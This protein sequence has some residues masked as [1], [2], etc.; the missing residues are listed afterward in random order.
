MKYVYVGEWVNL[1]GMKW[2]QK[3]VKS[4]DNLR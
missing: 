1:S 3:D 4:V 2:I